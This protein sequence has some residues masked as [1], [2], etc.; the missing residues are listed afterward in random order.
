VTSESLRQLSDDPSEIRANLEQKIGTK[1]AERFALGYLTVLHFPAYEAAFGIDQQQCIA[2]K[3]RSM[4]VKRIVEHGDVIAVHPVAPG[5]FVLLAEEVGQYA[6]IHDDLEQTVYPKVNEALAPRD[7]IDP[8]HISCRLAIIRFNR[9]EDIADVIAHGKDL[10]NLH[11][12]T[13][14]SGRW[15]EQYDKNRPYRAQG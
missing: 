15:V 3:M 1:S 4:L 14:D 12:N 10:L 9:D 11:A 7:G 13:K 6:N 8:Q 2:K 5:E